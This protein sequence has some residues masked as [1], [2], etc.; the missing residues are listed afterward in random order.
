ME[1]LVS[2]SVLAVGVLTV[3]ELFPMGFAASAKGRFKT[4]ATQIA[5]RYI[6]DARTSSNPRLFNTVPAT[7][8]LET[9]SSFAVTSDDPDYYYRIFCESV[10]DPAQKYAEFT[11][12]TKDLTTLWRFTVTVR[13]PLRAASEWYT[14][15]INRRKA[16]EVQLATY[17]TD[18]NCIQTTPQ[19]SP[20]ARPIS[21]GDTVIYVND[22]RPFTCFNFN[23]LTNEEILDSGPMKYQYYDPLA[24][25][26]ALYM[27]RND[28][29]MDNIII[30]DA[31]SSSADITTA[32]TDRIVDNKETNKII[33]KIP[34]TGYALPSAS[35]VPG[36]LVLLH[37]VRGKQAETVAADPTAAGNYTAYPAA[38]TTIVKPYIAYKGG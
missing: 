20:T 19:T 26:N 2:I 10:I 22:I 37:P 28:M 21:V 34:D 29:R 13:G 24:P 33:D 23:S 12:T 18:R 6:E 17:I 4:K 25:A 5:Q 3:L 15:P 1:I 11:S 8:Q 35:A 7:A 9:A 36:R 32:F 31:S 14:I 30:I 16:V 38:V 27:Q